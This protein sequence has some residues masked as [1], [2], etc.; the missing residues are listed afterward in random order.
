MDNKKYKSRQDKRNYEENLKEEKTKTEKEM[1]K[2]REEMKKYY[3]M[4]TG[5]MKKKK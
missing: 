2:N 5:Q 1:A 3:L 4:I